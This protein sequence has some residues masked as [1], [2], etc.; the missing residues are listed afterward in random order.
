MVDTKPAPP[1]RRRQENQE[2]NRNDTPTCSESPNRHRKGKGKWND[3]KQS[4]E[5]LTILEKLNNDYG[6]LRP[7]QPMFKRFGEF[8]AED[9]IVADSGASP[10]NRDEFLDY[11]AKAASLQGSRCARRSNHPPSSV[12]LP[13]DPRPAPPTPMPRRWKWTKKTLYNRH[14]SEARRQPG[15]ASQACAIAPGT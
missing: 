10:E 2:A 1:V 14:I 3:T 5:D 9:F 8:L 12:T 4:A 15:S 6:P 11:I 13:S 7:V